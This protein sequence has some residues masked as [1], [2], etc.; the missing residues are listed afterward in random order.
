MKCQKERLHAQCIM[1]KKIIYHSQSIYIKEKIN[2][3]KKA[4]QVKTNQ[5]TPHVSV[6]EEIFLIL[7]KMVAQIIPC[8]W[9][10]LGNRIKFCCFCWNC[11]FSEC[12]WRRCCQQCWRLKSMW[13]NCGCPCIH[14]VNRN[15]LEGKISHNFDNP[16]FN[17]TTP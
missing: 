14:F 10:C 3:A 11:A 4:L 17:K 9:V 2:N 12:S 1:L 7:Y 13:K 6:A 5:S 15:F 16:L 8:V